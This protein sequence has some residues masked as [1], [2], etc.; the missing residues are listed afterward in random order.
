MSSTSFVFQYPSLSCAAKQRLMTSSMIATAVEAPGD[1]PSIAQIEPSADE[2][3]SVSNCSSGVT[4][5]QAF[6]A[7]YP[8]LMMVVRR[9]PWYDEEPAAKTLGDSARPTEQAMGLD[10]GQAAPP[11][12]SVS[13]VLVALG[14]AGNEC[15]AEALVRQGRIRLNDLPVVAP[16][17]LWPGGRQRLSLNGHRCTAS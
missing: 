9:L 13:Q 8:E 5:R 14:I 7:P 6:L 17:A 10:A 4:E 11:T 2:T 16:F 12:Y 1:A 15:A 3:S